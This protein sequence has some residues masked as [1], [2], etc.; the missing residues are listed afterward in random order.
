MNRLIILTFLLF[1]LIN[2]TGNK[3]YKVGDAAAWNLLGGSNEKVG[4]MIVRNG[5]WVEDYEDTLNSSHKLLLVHKGN[6][7]TITDSLN[8]GILKIGQS[9]DYGTVELNEI[10]DP[11]LVALYV[12]DDSFYHKSIIKA[13]KANTET[14]KFQDFPIKGIRVKN[15]EQHYR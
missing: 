10:E 7:K 2:C 8:I 13:W 11:E 14:G 3:K 12:K 5:Y 6:Y 9:V 15:T 4:E 1:T